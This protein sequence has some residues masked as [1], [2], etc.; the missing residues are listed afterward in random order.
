MVQLASEQTNIPADRLLNSA[1][2]GTVVDRVGQLRAEYG[3]EGR[4]FA[5]DYAEYVNSRY[6]DVASVLVYEESFGTRDR[7]HLMYNLRSLDKYELLRDL[8]YSDSGLR[9]LMKRYGASDGTDWA[10]LFV[11]GSISET[12]LIPQA[13]GMYG[14]S[15][16]VPDD[17]EVADGDDA[18]V[19]PSA[20]YQTTLPLDKVLHS[21]N[22]GV[23]IHRTVQAKYKFRAEAR[24]FAREVAE[25]I[26]S[27]QVGQTSCFLYEEAFGP[28]DRLNWLIHMREAN[29]YY[30]LIDMH[31]RMDDEVRD[32]YLR[33]RI[34]PE[35]GGGTWNQLFVEETMRD[36]A[37]SPV[38]TSR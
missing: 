33:D 16:A 21:G 27:R 32:I 22:S 5:L 11:D 13:W 17:V 10:P 25:S 4:R 3:G 35:K 8:P 37:F 30:S 23:I 29:S 15:E 9:D 28:A 36:V 7:V 34:A 18:F 31:V 20:Q 24:M 1:T 2:A 26:N 12:A 14:T 38:C 19:V 6:S